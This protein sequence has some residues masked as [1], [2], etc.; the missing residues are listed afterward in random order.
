MK[1]KA[2]SAINATSASDAP[3]PIP[4]AA[5]ALSL[6]PPLELPDEAAPV[7]VGGV[8]EA[9]ALLVAPGTDQQL[10]NGHGGSEVVPAG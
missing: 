7:A 3:T 5:P 2:I 10:F 4:A 6:L 9:D 1:R 8:S